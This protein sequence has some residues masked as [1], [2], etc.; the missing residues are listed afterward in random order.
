MK[1][2]ECILNQFLYY[3]YTLKNSLGDGLPLF[4]DNHRYK[5]NYERHNFTEI[6][7]V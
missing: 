4:L 6:I 2:P 1:K 5:A 7:I 3:L